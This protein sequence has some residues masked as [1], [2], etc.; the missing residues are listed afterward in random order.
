GYAGIGV[1][2]TAMLG[3]VVF[4]PAVLSMLGPRIDKWA[5]WRRHPKD[6]GEGFWH[7]MAVFVMRRPVPIA[8]GVVLF[9]L[10]LGAPFLHVN[11]GL[12]DDRVLP[13]QARTRQVQDVIRSDFSSQEVASTRIV[14]PKFGNP[15]ARKHDVTVFAQ[16]VS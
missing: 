12:P 3:A 10:L 9:L 13:P 11:L 4:L 15:F 6:V 14:A 7:R 1:V 8:V 16:K 2:L 5:L